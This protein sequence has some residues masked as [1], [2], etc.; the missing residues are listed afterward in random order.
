[1]GMSKQLMMEALDAQEEVEALTHAANELAG[2]DSEATLN[3]LLA[4]A[5]AK[6]RDTQ[7]TRAQWN[8]T[9]T[10]VASVT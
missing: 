8:A 9:L 2:T 4:Q 10:R 7:A 5:Q 1:M 3:R 6:L